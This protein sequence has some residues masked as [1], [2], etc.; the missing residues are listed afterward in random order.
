LLGSWSPPSSFTLDVGK[1][2]LRRRVDQA[3]FYFLDESFAFASFEARLT[4]FPPSLASESGLLPFPSIPLA[5][6]ARRHTP[7][8]V[9]EGWLI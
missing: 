5:G 9:T 8:F 7:T 3:S 6:H 2:F 1:F 4:D